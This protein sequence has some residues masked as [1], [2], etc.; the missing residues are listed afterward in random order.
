VGSD[1]ELFPSPENIEQPFKDQA[2]PEI[3][4]IAAKSSKKRAR[5]HPFY[6]P[7]HVRTLVT[8]R[9]V[10]FAFLNNPP[11]TTVSV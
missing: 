7:E 11:T 4:V 3:R 5:S 10:D 8:N 6:D 9:L 2:S 1:P